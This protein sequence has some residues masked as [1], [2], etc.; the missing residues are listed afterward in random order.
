MHHFWGWVVAAKLKKFSAGV[1]KDASSLRWG[2]G[3]SQNQ[4][5]PDA[6]RNQFLSLLGYRL[7]PEEGFQRSHLSKQRIS[8]LLDIR[9]ASH[10][11]NN[12]TFHSW[13]TPAHYSGNIRTAK[14]FFLK[15]GKRKRKRSRHSSYLWVTIRF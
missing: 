13:S 9:Q 7:F 6:V 8:T 14:I 15:I 11:Q 5:L 3:G 2:A 1:L 10:A 12:A 4:L